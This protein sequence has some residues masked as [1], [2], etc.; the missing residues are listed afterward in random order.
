MILKYIGA[1]RHPSYAALGRRQVPGFPVNPK[2][3][4]LGW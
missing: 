2:G 1:F 4:I 3:G